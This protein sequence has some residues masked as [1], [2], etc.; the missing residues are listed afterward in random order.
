MATIILNSETAALTVKE[1]LLRVA[2]GEIEIRDEA[3][4]VLAYLVSPS[5]REQRLYAA[6][7]VEAQGDRALLLKRSERQGG[8]TTEEL[9]HKLGIPH[10][11]VSASNE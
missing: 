11:G 2:S 3:G 6:A 5:S 10:H 4:T 7:E 1:L 8:V 9:C